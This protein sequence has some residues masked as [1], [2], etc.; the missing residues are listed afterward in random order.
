MTLEAFKCKK[1]FVKFLY[2]FFIVG[3]NSS[4][5]TADTPIDNN[6]AHQDEE[7]E[8]LNQE[9]WKSLQING[10]INA[11]LVTY[12]NIA[13]SDFII[14][15]KNVNIINYMVNVKAIDDFYRV[16]IFIPSKDNDN[17]FSS[18]FEYKIN[19][20]SKVITSRTGHH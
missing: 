8:I 9:Q 4:C 14:F 6:D 18:L 15:K 17:K 19:A 13:V 11:N 5:V 2:L 1:W 3:I 10:T 16:M 7:A 20:L 12:A